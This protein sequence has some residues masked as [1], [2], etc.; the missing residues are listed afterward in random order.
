[1]KSAFRN[2]NMASSLA[3]VVICILSTSSYSSP[4]TDLLE[5]VSRL[6]RDC[7]RFYPHADRN[8]AET[9]VVRL[10]V[11]VDSV[12]RL[13]ESLDPDD[14][15]NDVRIPEL[16][17]LLRQLQYL[18]NRWEM[19]A[20]R[21]SSCTTVRPI[22]TLP[23]LSGPINQRAG[24]PAYEISTHQLEFL[25]NR[26]RFNWSQIS[27]ML[28]VSRTTLWRRIRNLESF[29]SRHHYTAI[30]DSDSDELIR[31]LRQGFPNS[32]ISMMLGHLRSRNIFVQRQRVRES[33]VRT[34]PAGSAMR[35]FNT[36]TRRV[37]SVRG[38]NSL[39]HIDGLH[40]L[41][42]WR[43][44][45][46]GGIDG[47]SRLIMY[48]SC[49]TNNYASTV[50]TL[51]LAAVQ[52]YG[53]PSRVRSDKGGENLDVARAMLRHRGLNRGSMIAGLSVHN[54]R[55]E[56]LWRDVFIGVGHFFYTLFYQMEENGILEST[57]VIDLFCLHYIFLPRI[58]HQLNLLVKAWNNHPVRTE[59]HWTP[60]Q[61]WV[62]GVISQDNSG[63]TAVRDIFAFA[64]S[65]HHKNLI[66]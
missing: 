62:N 6:L 7:S 5:T 32:G 12:R 27:R 46:H 40:C 43:F 30:T 48:L 45:I 33:L 15:G 64:Y 37:Y 3:L 10:Q 23:G 58:N 1:M 29:S 24:R 28:L 56:Q 22:R 54:Q 17:S 50:L 18:L 51:F 41:I 35:W 19:L 11:A 13:V 26:M 25:R 63:N 21:A 38:P 53:W 59:G 66:Q 52:R 2:A 31:G 65:G 42:R 61:I 36:I 49:A 14:Q 60:C 47:F 16:E 39:W 44:V 4:T 9:L 8:M 34:D 55:I 57:S 20:I